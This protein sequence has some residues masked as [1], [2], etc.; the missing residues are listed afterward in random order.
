V[1]TIDAEA[2]RAETRA[3]ELET[4]IALLRDAVERN[5]LGGIRL[6]GQDWFAWATC[7]GSSGVLLASERGIAEVLATSDGVRVLTSAIEADRLRAEELPDGLELVAFEWA[8][9]EERESFVLDATGTSSVASDL[10]SAGEVDLP[11]ALVIEKR[12]L[13]P[14][15]IVRYRE[16]GRAAAEAMTETLARVAPALT[17]LEVA[18]L[19]AEAM[20]RRGIEPALVLVAGARRIDLYRHPRPTVEPIGDRVAV[21]FCGRRHGLYA[22]LT[23]FAYFR[24]PTASERAAAAVVARVEA[25]A[26][27]ASTPG[28]TL[29]AIYATVADAY[30]RLGHPGAER[31]HHQGGTT[32]YLSR[33]ALATPDSRV[34]IEPPLALAWNPSLPGS[35]IEDTILRSDEELE[36]LTLDPTWPMVDV[37]GRERPDL[38]ILG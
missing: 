38:R 2:S 9:P 5:G 6:R 23:R 21:V 15:E 20:L 17:E 33:E 10:P 8:H 32:G 28:A 27:N 1:T 35:K 37:E 4:K 29:G 13:R 11:E 31:H 34:G 30:A 24:M 26:W 12:R 14:T 16:L 18:G 25:A 7:G 36:V 22:N 19:G 3:T